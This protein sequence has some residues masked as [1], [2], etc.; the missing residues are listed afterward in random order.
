MQTLT[1]EKRLAILQNNQFE[2]ILVEQP[3]HRSLVGNI[4]YGTVSD[5][6]PGMNAAFVDIGEDKK[7]F[8]YRNKLPSYV[9]ADTQK[10]S[11]SISQF[12][13]QG[14]KLLVQ[15]EKDATGTKGPRLTALIEIEGELLIYIPHGRYVAVSKKHDDVTRETWRDI[16]RQMK[17]EEEGFIF[18]TDCQLTKKEDVLAELDDLRVQ[19]ATIEQSA[20]QCKKP[21][22]LFEK[23]SFFDY[24]L[25]EITVF[26][27]VEVIVDE[28]AMK[29]K[30]DHLY[31]N[32]TKILITLANMQ[33]RIFYTHEIDKEIDKAM[34]RIVWLQNGA[35]IVFDEAEA[36]TIIDVNTGKYVGKSNLRQTVLRVNELAMK[37]IARQ[38]RL[39]DIG[40]IILIDFIDMK[41]EE[42][43]SRIIEVA[44]REFVNDRKR[45][46]IVG[47]TSL[48]I[49]QLTRK[50]TNISLSESLTE[51]CRVCHGT[52]KI[53]SAE[54]VAYQLERQLWE[55]RFSDYEA[56]LIEATDDVIAT[57]SGDN[58]IHRKR[59]EETLKFSI[60]FSPIKQEQPS[61]AI[62]QFG[63]KI[64]IEQTIAT[65]SV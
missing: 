22:L 37:E 19:Y 56:I 2:Q 63:T 51:N 18:R 35:Y 7:G 53:N 14:E 10:Q 36:C 49:L 41:W 52:G 15:V 62:R 24:L 46:N 65:R 42:D 16:G 4:Y 20:D 47:F 38:I 17:T 28:I 31:Q 1:N 30:L 50:K 6:V 5:I 61:F 39:R 57:F 11:Q 33:E 59:L 32:D 27:S 64:E 55:Y 25:R 21:T 45:T 58:D 12:L 40:G 54:T 23:D 13:H 3:K 9:Q 60:C 29:R 43:R 48:G 34:K 8:L 44:K 26:G